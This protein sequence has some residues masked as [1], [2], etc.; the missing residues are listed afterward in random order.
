LKSQVSWVSEVRLSITLI[1]FYIRKYLK[2][3]FYTSTTFKHLL[4]IF[5]SKHYK[6][7]ALFLQHQGCTKKSF[8]FLKI[9]LSENFVNQKS[10]I[11]W[12]F[13]LFRLNKLIKVLI[14]LKQTTMKVIILMYLFKKYY[15][16]F[17]I[18]FFTHK[19]S[20]SEKQ[21]LN[22]RIL[23]LQPD[24]DGVIYIVKSLSYFS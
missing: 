19:K 17:V 11:Y 4:W 21:S 6:K 22:I 5:I 24:P 3:Q 20:G 23:P 15:I 10:A 2:N 9:I 7:H 13:E 12:M 14:V 18:F 8:W 1:F 16:L